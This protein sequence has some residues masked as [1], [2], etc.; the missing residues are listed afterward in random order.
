MA[1]AADNPVS[2]FFARAAVAA[3][4]VAGMSIAALTVV[5]ASAQLRIY[6]GSNATNTPSTLPGHELT[7]CLPP[8]EMWNGKCVKRCSP[9]LVHKLPDGKCGHDPSFRQGTSV[10]AV[11]RCWWLHAPAIARFP[12][13]CP[14]PAGAAVGDACQCPSPSGRPTSG[15][16]R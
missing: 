2:R 12:I 9:G 15:I 3:L 8:G 7:V 11:R 5:P 4:I 13:W 14:A 16:V 6:D 10:Q 1:R